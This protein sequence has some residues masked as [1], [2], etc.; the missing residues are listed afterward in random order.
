MDATLPYVAFGELP[1]HF[2]MGNNGG[3]QQQKVQ[4]GLIKFLENRSIN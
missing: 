4:K 2:V 1:E 3:R